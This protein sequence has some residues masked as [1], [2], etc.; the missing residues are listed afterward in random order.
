MSQE[1]LQRMFEATSAKYT[2]AAEQAAQGPITS[3]SSDAVHDNY[4]K[5]VRTRMLLRDMTRELAIHDIQLVSPESKQRLAAPAVH[6]KK[7]EIPTST[8]PATDGLK[9]R[10]FRQ[11]HERNVA[12]RSFDTYTN[13]SFRQFSPDQVRTAAFA[14]LIRNNTGAEDITQLTQRLYS[15]SIASAAPLI[16]PLLETDR[17]DFAMDTLIMQKLWRKAPYFGDADY[18]EA[19]LR[20]DPDAVKSHYEDRLKLEAPLITWTTENLFPGVTLAVPEAKT[21]NVVAKNQPSLILSERTPRSTTALEMRPSMPVPVIIDKPVPV[22]SSEYFGPPLPAPLIE[23]AKAE[24]IM[25]T[26]LPA[27]V[28]RTV[29]FA[30]PPHLAPLAADEV[31]ITQEA[32]KAEFVTIFD[33]ELPIRKDLKVA[34]VGRIEYIDVFLA[35]KS[36]QAAL[37]REDMKELLVVIGIDNSERYKPILRKQLKEYR[38]ARDDIQVDPSLVGKFAERMFALAIDRGHK[39]PVDP[40]CEFG[41]EVISKIRKLSAAQLELFLPHTIRFT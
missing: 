1:H 12:S 5:A 32:T 33:P 2:A 36:I 39:V 27:P 19:L 20:R 35:L 17:T 6:I 11:Y 3:A 40:E 37:G 34:D 28:A 14:S 30:P 15:E 38:E 18:I 7:A 25:D 16:K 22:L 26:P 10:S 23:I 13:G 29:S 4:Y 21:V 41:V 31:I 24:E 9:P 8:A